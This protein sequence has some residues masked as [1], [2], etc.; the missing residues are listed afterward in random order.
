[1]TVFKRI[2]FFSLFLLLI[3]AIGFGIGEYFSK[4]DAKNMA[5]SHQHF[6]DMLNFTPDQRDKLIPI[7]KKYA[8]QKALYENQIRQ[9]NRE[10]GE[11]MK[12]EKTYTPKVQAAVK[13]IHIAMGHLQEITLVHFFDMRVL[14]DDRQR[15]ILDDYVTDAMHEH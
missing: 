7:E 10:L 11:I 4:N 5:A 14:L 9:A 8:D 15:Q 12:K 6:H 2:I 3:I 1:M 13:K